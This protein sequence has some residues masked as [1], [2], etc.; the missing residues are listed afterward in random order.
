[1]HLPIDSFFRSLAKEM[2]ITVTNFFRDREA[3]EKLQEQVIAPLVSQKAPDSFI[4]IWAAGCATGEEAYSIAMIL[5]EEITRIQKHFSIEIFATD[6]D[7]ESIETGRR[8]QYP[9]S[10]AGDVSPARLKRFF[11]EENNHYKIKS[12]IREMMVFA[13][14]NLTKDSPFSKLDLLCCRNVL[15]YMDSTLQKKLIPM[16]H[17]T[18]NP[19]GILFL[20]ESES[21]GTSSDL[22]TPIDAR[23]KIFR[24]K[25]VNTGYEPDTEVG[26][27]PQAEPATL[28]LDRTLKIRRFT[29]MA[30]KMFRLIERD[31]GRPLADIVTNLRYE[32]LIEDIKAVLESL[33][34]VEKEVQGESDRYYRMRIVPYRT[35]ENVIDGAVITFVD[36][37]GQQEGK[38]SSTR[39]L[40]THPTN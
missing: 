10:I 15:I 18:L 2:L 12:V 9:K 31:V 5:Y 24:R 16:F 1:V 39:G 20:G 28:F 8:G 27:Y 4:R 26:D 37:T 30:R 11:I 23:H 34:R 35:A 14:H 38:Y 19:G 13:K 21:I 36:I 7:E 33:T 40:R 3:F 22:F 17:C 25:P 6:I 32:G 29:P